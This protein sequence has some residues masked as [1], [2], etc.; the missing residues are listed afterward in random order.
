MSKPVSAR[1]LSRSV[2]MNIERQY[3]AAIVADPPRK[4]IECRDMSKHWKSRLSKVGVGSFRLRLINGMTHPIP[5]AEVVVVRL[6]TDTI[7]RQYLLHLGGVVA[8]KNW[9]RV[10]EVPVNDEKK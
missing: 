6:E 10:N 2:T 7:N 5:E 4:T 8:L 3:F 1:S 9:D